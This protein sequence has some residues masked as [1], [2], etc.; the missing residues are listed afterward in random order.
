MMHDDDDLAS[1][2]TSEWDSYEPPFLRGS[3][4]IRDTYIYNNITTGNDKGGTPLAL[5]S[6]VASNGVNQ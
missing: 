5:K 6:S 4:V 3:A 2:L 1:Y